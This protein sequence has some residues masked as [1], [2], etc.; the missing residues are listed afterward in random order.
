MEDPSA[1]YVL[2]PKAGD[3]NWTEIQ[4]YLTQLLEN[5]AL[6]AEKSTIYV[7][8]GGIGYNEAYLAHQQPVE[9]YPYLNITFGGN[10]ALQTYSGN[11]VY[12]FKEEP[13]VAAL[14]A[15]ADHFSTEWSS[16]IPEGL[17]NIYG[18]D[19]VIILG[20]PAPVVPEGT[21]APTDITETN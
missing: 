14:E 4:A 9:A 12:N 19:I 8:N 15:L 17:T 21:T 2:T 5:P 3:G 1:A 20:A 16:E 6:F 11:N 13:H 18:E 10:A 7:Y